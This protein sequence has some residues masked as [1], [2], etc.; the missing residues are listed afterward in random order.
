MVNSLPTNAGD[1]VSIPESGRCPGG[2][3]GSP[4]WYSCLEKEDKKRRGQSRLV[5]CSPWGH[6]ES[7]MTAHTDT[8]AMG[9]AWAEHQGRTVNRTDN[10]PCPEEGDTY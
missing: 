10:S 4:S 9:Q 6:K 7:D 2:G 8:R 3:N 5:G 1:A